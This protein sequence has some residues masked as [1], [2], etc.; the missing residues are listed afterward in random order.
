MSVPLIHELRFDHW[1]PFYFSIHVI[2]KSI[3]AR[4]YTDRETN[5]RTVKTPLFYQCPQTLT[6]NVTFQ[7]DDPSI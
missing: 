7:Q 4:S 6:S 2:M 5:R 3:Y 1:Y